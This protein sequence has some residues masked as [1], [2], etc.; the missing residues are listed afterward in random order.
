MSSQVKKL[1]KMKQKVAENLPALTEVLRGTFIKWRQVCARRSCKC[2]KSKKYQHGPF[3]RV[4]F[5]KK[6]RSHHIYVPLKD[7]KKIK[8]WVDNYN[9][10]WQG[11]EE[12]SQINIKLIR[13][14][15]TK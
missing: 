9:K 14:G 5:S 8:I 12:I 3:Y 11:I 1:N 2:H 4:S 15:A 6:G 10:L 13:L 7:K